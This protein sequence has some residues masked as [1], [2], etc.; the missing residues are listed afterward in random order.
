MALAP[1]PTSVLHD[2]KPLKISSRGL[3]KTLEASHC[4]MRMAPLHQLLVGASGCG[5]TE[6]PARVG[7]GL[8]LP[9]LQAALAEITEGDHRGGEWVVSCMVEIPLPLLCHALPLCHLD[10]RA[11]LLSHIPVRPMGEECLQ[12]L[13]V[14]TSPWPHTTAPCP[15]PSSVLAYQSH[16]VLEP[17][18][19]SSSYHHV[20]IRAP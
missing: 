12:L 9:S 3:W 15:C 7:H 17:D 19:T 8:G 2:F 13:P 18:P 20:S 10:T 16:Q 5:N 11:L 1:V 6:A 14:T 4:H